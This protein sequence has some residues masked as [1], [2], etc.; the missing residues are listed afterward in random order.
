MKND[1]MINQTA[2]SL[3]ERIKSIPIKDNW[4]PLPTELTPDYVNVPVSL[5]QILR[6]L[7]GVSKDGS[8]RVNRISWSIAQDVIIAVSI[9]VVKTSEH[10]LLPWVIKSLM[11]PL[12]R[13][14][15][16]VQHLSNQNLARTLNG[17]LKPET[18]VSV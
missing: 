17:G 10:I 8:T 9:G 5:Q 12:H 11:T 13:A 3:R 15:A 6:V 14:V 16:F 4:P 7:L 2:I 1:N 18:P